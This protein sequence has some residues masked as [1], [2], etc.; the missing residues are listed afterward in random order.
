MSSERPPRDIL[1][2][3]QITVPQRTRHGRNEPVIQRPPVVLQR[4]PAR[5]IEHRWELQVRGS[6]A[7]ISNQP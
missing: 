5:G 3:T 7:T 4:P 2:W 1:H 6:E